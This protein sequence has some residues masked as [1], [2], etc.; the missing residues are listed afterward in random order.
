MTSTVT[1]PPCPDRVVLLRRLAILD[2]K[3][4]RSILVHVRHGDPGPPGITGIPAGIQH[5]AGR[6]NKDTG[7]GHYPFQFEARSAARVSELDTVRCP[8]G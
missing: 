4:I 3:E 5:S 1:A 8:V 6:P 7:Q 2:L